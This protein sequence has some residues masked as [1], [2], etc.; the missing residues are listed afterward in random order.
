MAD[1]KEWENL[2]IETGVDSMIDYLAEHGKASTKEIAK[3]IGVDKARCEQW[4][5]ALAQEN[6]IHKHHTITSGLVLEYTDDNIREAEKKKEEIKEEV[7]QKSED[8]QNHLESRSGALEERKDYLVDKKGNLDEKD[9]KKAVQQTIERLEII[10]SRINRRLETDTLDDQTIDLIIEI[11]E[12]LKK[13]EELIRYH[14][15][16]EQGRKLDKKAG[17]AVEQVQT[18]LQYTEEND[19]YLEKEKE[20]RRELKAMKKLEKNIQKARESKAKNNSGNLLD[21]IKSFL[22]IKKQSE[23][24]SRK[25]MDKNVQAE[26]TSELSSDQKIREEEVPEHSYSELVNENRITE[27]MRKISLI[28]EPDYEALMKAEMANRARP[29][30]VNYLEERVEDGR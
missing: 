1:S 28:K 17:E 4:A 19:E 6:L 21:K 9:K 18:V 11:E 20:I 30:L 5:D 22:P 14:L 26:N 3:E 25:E 23:D 16:D 29:E 15:E 12:I 10:E 8:L 27:V 2:V 7:S 13:V 24:S